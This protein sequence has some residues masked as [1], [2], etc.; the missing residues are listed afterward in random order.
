MKFGYARVSTKAQNLD[1]Q[2]DALKKAG[3]DQIFT[4]QLSGSISTRAAVSE[5][6]KFLRPGDTVII[7]KFDRLARSLKHLIKLLDDYGKRGINL[8]SLTEKIDVNEVTGKFFYHVMGA[9]S[10]FEKDILLE[11]SRDGMAAARAR[12]RIGGRPNKFTPQELKEMID[13]YNDKKLKVNQIC[14]LYNITKPTFYKYLYEYH[15]NHV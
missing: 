15:K 1:L 3:C 9:L 4:E 5:M 6:D 13:H 2:I 8:I 12:G 14:K 10:E 11:R 7:Y